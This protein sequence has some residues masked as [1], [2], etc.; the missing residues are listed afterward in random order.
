M[1]SEETDMA[2]LPKQDLFESFELRG[3][4]WDPAR[5]ETKVPGKL[6]WDP[7]EGG[8]LELASRFR[9]PD[10]NGW[11]TALHGDTGDGFVSRLPVTLQNVL[12][13]R[14]RSGTEHP[15]FYCTRMLC[16]LH[17][18]PEKPYF[19]VGTNMKLDGLAEWY[20][21]QPWDT[22]REFFSGNSA[23]SEH[24]LTIKDTPLTVCE[25]PSIGG[26]LQ[27]T[28]GGARS[29][30]RTSLEFNHDV[31][32]FAHCNPKP[33][34]EWRDF[35]HA[36]TRLLCLLSG[37]RA[38]P[39]S[40]RLR[41][42]ESEETR[43]WL[44]A[45]EVSVYFRHERKRPD[46][47]VIGP[48]M[49]FQF[50][51]L[52]KDR[53]GE[54]ASKWFTLHDR[55]KDCMRLLFRQ[56]ERPGDE[57]VPRF[58]SACQMFEAYHRGTR[59][60]PYAP[61]ER[62]AEWLKQMVAAIPADVEPEHRQALKSRLRFGNQRSLRTRL[63]TTFGALPDAIRARLNIDSSVDANRITNAR[64]YHTHLDDGGS[65]DVPE[66]GD[67][68]PLASNLVMTIGY[69]IWSDL[70]LGDLVRPHDVLALWKLS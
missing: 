55:L 65:T 25:V 58:L 8:T 47:S 66:E 69:L 40:V 56:V 27:L 32:L 17:A 11:D 39:K 45:K 64:N 68:F 9:L 54:V 53:F 59:D 49:P 20:G 62:Y 4:W 36:Q 12:E 44:Y 24:T 13:G 60:N 42:S 52:G 61:A 14:N 7:H 15:E 22:E 21:F 19:L 70:G 6:S 41:L 3:Q 16:G 10:G 30:T 48:E 46:H 50:P 43:D 37:S 28:G 1:R 5:P 33:L 67:L 31:T 23:G 26:N 38:H 57:I 2:F 29:F 35:I 51:R 34:H 63:R 18:V